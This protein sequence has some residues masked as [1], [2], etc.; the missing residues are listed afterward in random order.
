MEASQLGEEFALLLGVHFSYCRTGGVFT[1]SRNRYFRNVYMLNNETY[2][3]LQGTF[4][5]LSRERYSL[6]GILMYM[7]AN[8]TMLP[9]CFIL[10]LL[11][12]FLLGKKKSLFTQVR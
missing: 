5:E 12:S 4:F 2:N 3:S 10:V 6:Q 11:Y 8:C 7:R 1:Q 9:A